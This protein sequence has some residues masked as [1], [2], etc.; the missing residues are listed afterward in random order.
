MSLPNNYIN[1]PNVMFEPKD[2]I[3]LGKKYTLHTA[4]FNSFTSLYNYLISNPPTNDQVFPILQSEECPIDIA[5][6]PYYEALQDL[7][8][9][10]GQQYNEFLEFEKSLSNAM[11]KE[12]SKYEIVK[13]VSGGHLNIPAYSAGDPLCFD[14]LQRTKKTKF[15]KIYVLISYNGYTKESQVINR[16]KIIANIIKALE[17]A[18][19]NVELEAFELSYL[20]DEIEYT[21]VKIK[22]HGEKIRMNNLYK[23]LC[24]IEFFRRIIFRVMETMDFR[25]YWGS[26]YGNKCNKSFTQDFLKFSNRD[27]Y[28]DQPSKMGIRGYDLVED[29][30]NV[31]EYLNLEDKIDIEKAKAGFKKELVKIKK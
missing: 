2:V 17:N 20:D 18:G 24:H 22:N 9:P 15:I 7:L 3:V 31:I 19:Y 21:V 28:F 4:R 30:E 16:T 13:T 12:S 11:L 23:A 14:D 5:G 8:K 29:F 1:H 26:G 25:N 6:K 10:E 27:I